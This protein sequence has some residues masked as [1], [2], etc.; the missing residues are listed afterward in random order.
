M[1]EGD[2]GQQGVEGGMTKRNPET[3]S[4]VGELLKE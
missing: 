1:D 4:N 3:K 2:F